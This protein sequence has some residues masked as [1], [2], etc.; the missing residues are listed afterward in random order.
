[1]FKI[2]KITMVALFSTMFAFTSNAAEFRVGA[3]AGFAQLEASGTET[4]KDS[5]A[6]TTL[7]EQ[8]NAIIPSLFVEL[9]RDSGIGLGIDYVP[10]SADLAGS[11]RSRT[12]DGNDGQDS[13]TQTANAEVDGVTT[14]YLIKMFDSGLFVKAGISQADINTTETLASGSSYGNKSVDGSHFGAGVEK[15]NDS[16]VF[17]RAGVEHTNFDTIT[18]TGDQV[19]VAASGSFNTISADVDITAAKFSIGKRF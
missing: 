16:G 1:M 9:S 7:T 18:L 5:A 2:T 14:F 10:G 11:N 15:S 8:A 4:L 17:F 13:G 12:L 3:S 6:T 19:G